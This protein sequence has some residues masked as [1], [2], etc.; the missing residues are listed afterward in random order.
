MIAT[1]PAID[2]GSTMS[3]CRASGGIVWLVAPRISSNSAA[4][5]EMGGVTCPVAVGTIMKTST[6]LRKTNCSS[7][8]TVA[9]TWALTTITSSPRTM[10]NVQK[11]NTAPPVVPV[12]PAC[13][14]GER[15]AR[16]HVHNRSTS[17]EQ[18]RQGR[19]LGA[20]DRPAAERQRTEHHRIAL[21]EDERIPDENRQQARRNHRV[22][23][24]Q[25]RH[26]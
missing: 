6:A 10:T 1:A 22:R 9:A 20:H 16:C 21:V 11:T 3:A 8:P 24:K 2:S 15:Q 25:H 4:N 19:K 26:L 5:Q 13:D 18:S 12:R 7:E 17:D 23:H 14:K